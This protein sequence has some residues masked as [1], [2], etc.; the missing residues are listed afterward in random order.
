MGQTQYTNPWV[1]EGQ[2]HVCHQVQFYQT[3]NAS[4]HPKNIEQL[5]KIPWRR[6]TG[7]HNK[8]HD[9]Q[10]FL[11]T[12]ECFSDMLSTILYKNNGAATPRISPESIGICRHPL[13]S[14]NPLGN[15]TILVDGIQARTCKK[16]VLAYKIKGTQQKT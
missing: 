16:Q 8:I 15:T 13:Q 5:P 4:A 11:T 9:C 6:I 1:P 10:Q 3:M 14:R 12:I 2:T 7:K